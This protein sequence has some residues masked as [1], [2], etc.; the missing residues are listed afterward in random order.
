MPYTSSTYSFN[1]GANYSLIYILTGS[2]FTAPAF[3]LDFTST[4]VNYISMFD[5]ILS[6]TL[7]ITTVS[8]TMSV[9][10]TKIYTMLTFVSSS[11]VVMPS[12]TINNNF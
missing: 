8:L 5:Q 1:T 7:N 2:Q 11:T 6:S 9:D 4:S 12:L 10:I 3:V